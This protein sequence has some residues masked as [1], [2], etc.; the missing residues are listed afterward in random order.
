MPTQ[1]EKPA[2]EKILYDIEISDYWG[3]KGWTLSVAQEQQFH[4]SATIDPK[5][6]AVE[7]SDAQLQFNNATLSTHTEGNKSV[8]NSQDK[9]VT[10]SNFNLVPGA[11]PLELVE[12][13]RKGQYLNQD[14]DNKGGV[15]YDIP[16]YS[17]HKY[18]FGDARTADYS[19]GLHVPETTERYRTEYTSTLK[20]HLTVA[21]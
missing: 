4:G 8:L 2:D 20:W 14:G 7:L 15:S 17:V 18:Q 3:I 6:Q 13:E 1:I 21:P 12:Y 11:E 9:V 5:E 10:K 16:G 19:I